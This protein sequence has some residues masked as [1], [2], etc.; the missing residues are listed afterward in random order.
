MATTRI[1]DVSKTTTD[2]A[3]DEYGIFDGA[4]NGT[5]KM[6]RND[7]YADW[8]AAYVAAPTTYNLAP[9]NSGTNK[10]DATYLPT[11]ADTAKGEWNAN[12]NTPTLADGG[13]TAGDYYDVTTA[14]SVDLGSGS[15]TYTVG[16]VV[17]YNGTTWY[18]I[19]S[20]ANVL[21]GSATASAGR[22]V[23]EVNSVDEDADATGTKL[24]SPSIYFD[25]TNDY[26]ETADSNKLSF[27]STADLGDSSGTWTATTNSPAI[28]DG[29]G[30]LNDNYKITVAGT[31]AQG[32]S[33]LSIIDGV[34][35]TAGQVVYYD[36]A[37]W[38]LKD[39]DDLP[40]SVGSWIKADTFQ[41]NYVA[42]KYSSSS[43]AE[44]AF[45]ITSAGD[46]RLGVY[47]DNS[48]YVTVTSTT[49]LTAY[50]GGYIHIMA[51]Y[52]GAG[53]NSGNAFSTAGSGITLYVNGQAVALDAPAETGT[54]TGMNNT[55]ATLL[56]GRL[57]ASSYSNHHQKDLKV[58]N[59]ELT[60]AEV[61]DSMNGDL[62]FADEWGGAGGGIYTSDFSAGV[63]GFSSGV[64]GTTDG[65]IDSISGEDNNLRFTCDSTSG[66]HYARRTVLTDGKSYK[67]EFDFYIPS[68]NSNLD[69]LWLLHGSSATGFANSSPAKDTWLTGSA[70]FTAGNSQLRWYGTDGGNTSFQDAGG[71]D[72]F[73]VRN[74]RVTQ[75]GAV[76]DARAERFDTNTDK[77]Y[78]LSDNGFIGT[79]NG[80]TLI[81]REVPVYETGTWTPTL[82]F[83]GGSTGM[84]Y[85]SQEGFYTR[86]GN[87]VF[88]T[89][90]FVLSAVG[91]STGA[92]AIALPYA[93]RNT[94][95]DIQGVNVGR[96]L[97]L[98]G[99]TSAVSGYIVDNTTSCKLMDWGA[100]GAV[101]L[102]ETN[103]TATTEINISATYQIS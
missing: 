27:T 36:G 3:S 35:A 66:S 17:K 60:A 96:G 25:G 102:A 43:L 8:A 55:A 29:T 67:V 50:A 44:Y 77:L 42:C 61:V 19:D 9:L 33:T 69:G 59:R 7:M 78:D 26:I 46:L 31:V 30:T 6:S 74:V 90:G 52:A 5:Q 14:G 73:Y 92:A 89:G 76:L 99:L 80:A 21:D 18:K 38:R 95:N 56:I 58:F 83:G 20:V 12:T 82:T 93:A 57:S 81:G 70:S 65:N 49:A 45:Y 47:S 98:T 101:D 85:T 1:K 51:T 91:S 79:N 71:N 10:I 48:N 87:T 84:T 39:A 94:A 28:T 16:D 68:S 54:Y 13:G 23:L 64:N 75:I 15:L 100:T 37:V 4:T 40:F 41:D 11:G 97:A 32:A 88:V 22:T 2:L 63:D 103:F 24:V 72:V 86:I 62:G 34:A 53:P